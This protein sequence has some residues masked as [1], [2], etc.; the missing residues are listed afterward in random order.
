MSLEQLSTLSAII[1]FLEST[2]AVTFNVTT[3]Y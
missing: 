1:Q 2:Q 3:Y